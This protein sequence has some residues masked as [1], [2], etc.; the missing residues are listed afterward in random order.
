MPALTD[1]QQA[2]DSLQK[3]FSTLL[4]KMIPA[5][6]AVP[7][8]GGRKFVDWENLGDEIERQL[9]SHFLEQRAALD[10]AAQVDG[11]IKC[12]HCASNRIYMIKPDE[13]ENQVEMLTPHGVVVIKKQ[14]C[15]CRA[16]NRSFSPSG[17]GMGF[18]DGSES[19][20]EGQ[21]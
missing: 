7:L 6:N 4:D 8:P 19:V 20:A 9:V 18:A 16:C 5:D 3:V 15:R 21:G 2:R 10:A 13:R 14:R 11:D 12:P 1:R 17:P